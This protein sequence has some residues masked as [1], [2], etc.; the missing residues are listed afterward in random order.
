MEKY[1][2]QVRYR[3]DAVATIDGVG[4][5]KETF[6]F[7]AFTS[8]LTEL[9]DWLTSDGVTHVAMESTGI[10]WKPVY[11]VLDPSIDNVWIANA[12]HIKNVPGHKT[13]RMDSEWICKLLLAGLLKS[14]VMFP[15]RTAPVARPYPLSQKVYTG[16][17]L[18]QES[19]NSRVRRLQYKIVKRFVRYERGYG[20]ITY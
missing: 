13:D 6:E 17:S 15:K 1:H 7:R 18:R 12:R 11:N 8:S 5:E 14:L 20:H 10:Y 19:G 2:F 16:S 3:V 4:L 9:G